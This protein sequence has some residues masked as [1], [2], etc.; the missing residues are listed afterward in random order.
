MA[1]LVYRQHMYFFKIKIIV[2]FIYV[3]PAKE[4]ECIINVM[5]KLNT[6]IYDLNDAS[7]LSI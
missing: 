5:W 2:R 6:T 1:L 7:S 4:T 3:N